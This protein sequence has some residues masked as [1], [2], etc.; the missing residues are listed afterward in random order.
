MPYNY[1]IINELIFDNAKDAYNKETELK[2][3]NKKHKY[4]PKNS[5]FGQNECFDKINLHL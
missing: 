3:L 4:I 5:F 1:E 2:R